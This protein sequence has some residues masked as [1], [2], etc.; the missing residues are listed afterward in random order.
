MIDKYEIKVSLDKGLY[1]YSVGSHSPSI[2]GYSTW[3][4]AFQMG[5]LMVKNMLRVYP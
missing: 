1:H 4:E 5:V 2:A 3:D